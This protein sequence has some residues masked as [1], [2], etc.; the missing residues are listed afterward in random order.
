MKDRIIF[1]V[2]LV[3]LGAG[4]LLDQFGVVSFSDIISVYWP[5][6]LIIIGVLGLFKKNSSKLISGL[7]L[8]F[9]ILFQI[10]KLGFLKVDIFK[11]FWP[12]V[13]IALGFSIIFS[14]G[15]LIIRTGTG[16]K[17]GNYD[18]N[19]SLEN[20]IDESAIMAGI[21]RNVH[22]QEF[23]G[24]KVTV[25][26][27][28]VDLDLREAKLYNNEAH[29]EINTIMGGVDIYVPENWRVEHKGTPILGGFTNKRK[30]SGDINAPLLVIN[31]SAI[32]GGI[33]VK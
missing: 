7:I 12:V 24:G 32:M 19:V 23:R 5:L 29:L 21:E 27:G 3:L 8:I 22:S 14:R 15:N 9:G 31:F 2:I 18:K 1:G 10:Q 16:Y 30:Y 33:E 17:S 6:I 28:G 4:F 26:M 25:I 13:L 11:T 20:V